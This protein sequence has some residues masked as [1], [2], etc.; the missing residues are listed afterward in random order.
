MRLNKDTVV[1][2]HI[3]WYIYIFY[4]YVEVVSVRIYKKLA[5]RVDCGMMLK[6]GLL[7]SVYLYRFFALYVNFEITVGSQE[8]AKIVQN[9]H[10]FSAASCNANI[11]PVLCAVLNFV[12]PAYFI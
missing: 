9:S 5:I 12:F 11:T 6:R 7:L 1:Y 8:V 3:L 4:L 2:M 10:S